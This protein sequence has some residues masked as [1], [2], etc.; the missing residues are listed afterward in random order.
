MAPILILTG[1]F[2]RTAFVTKQPHPTT[3]IFQESRTALAK[4]LVAISTTEKAMGRTLLNLLLSQGLSR[5]GTL[6][7]YKYYYDRPSTGSSNEPRSSPL[8]PVEAPMSSHVAPC[9]PGAAQPFGLNGSQPWYPNSFTTHGPS[10][11][12]T[13]PEAPWTSANYAFGRSQT[14]LGHP[15][16]ISPIG[17]RL[18]AVHGLEHLPQR[19]E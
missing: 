10:A 15:Q 3:L 1:R 14:A 18:A 4:K 2:H 6:G 13:P 7:D 9:N 8:T 12:S 16:E 5:T 11:T 19:S 17:T